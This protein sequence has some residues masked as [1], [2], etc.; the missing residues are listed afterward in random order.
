[1][2]TPWSRVCWFAIAVAMAA[3]AQA[4][5]A[6]R[7]NPGTANRN[8]PAAT[9]PPDYVIGPDDVLSIVFPYEKD[10]SSD[11]AVRPDGM[12]SLPLITTSRRWD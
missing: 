10:L 7:T 8:V 4:Q 3:A 9:P 2:A 6:P 12:I 5:T 11:V 1:M